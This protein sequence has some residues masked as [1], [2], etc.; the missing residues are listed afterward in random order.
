M[1]G[2]FITFEGPEGSG[3]TSVIRRV[4][5][6]YQK[7]GYKVMV[8]REPGGVRIAELI[9]DIIMDK[10]HTEM[11]PRT[12]AL[13]FAASRR[14]HLIEKILPALK[15]GYLVLCDRFVD[16]SLAYQGYGRKLGIEEVF[17]INKFAIE[18]TMPSLTIFVDVK[19]E[20]G[21]SRVFNSH[22]REVNRLDLEKLEF[23]KRIYEGF[24]ILINKFPNRV[25]CIDG[26]KPLNEVVDQAIKLIDSVI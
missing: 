12:E 22:N 25:K 23:H 26:E 18:E 4:L 1:M 13:L 5:A 14:Q 9:R 16:S 3:K 2:K 7:K 17:A 19:P 8:T 15:E 6:H 11:D 24:E 21:L 20:V 10:S